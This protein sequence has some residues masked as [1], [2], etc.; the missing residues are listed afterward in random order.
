MVYRVP[1]ETRCIQSARNL[2]EQIL[3]F[4]NKV[5]NSYLNTE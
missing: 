1:V 2:L 5:L 3:L 4:S